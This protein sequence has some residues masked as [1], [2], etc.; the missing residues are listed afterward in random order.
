MRTGLP[1]VLGGAPVV[2]DE[3]PL[4]RPSI[5]LDPELTSALDAVLASGIITKGGRLA[6]LERQVAAFIG[7]EHAVAVSSCTTG[8]MLVLRCLGRTGSVIL[9]SFTF[10]ASGHAALWNGLD[11]VLADIDPDTFTLAPESAARMLD[12]DGAAVMGVHTFGAPCDADALTK[13]ANERGVPLVIDAAP[14]FGARYPDGTM[15][16]TKGIAEVFS[17]SPTK[18]FTTGEGGLIATDDADLARRLRIGRE[19]GNPGNFDSLFVGLNGRM[20]E[21]SAALGLHNLPHLPRWLER[22]EELAERYRAG[23]SDLPGIGFQRI[24]AG[25][26]ST[27]KDFCLTVHA[28]DFGL[29]RDVLA[30]ALG[31]ERVSTRKYFVPPLHRQTV[32]RG[33]AG[34][35]GAV[36]HSEALAG[37]IITVP[38]WSAMTDHQ[39]EEVCAVI[40]RIHEHAGDV[41]HAVARSAALR[42]G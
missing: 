32:Y 16:G 2:A 9:P 24:P 25:A 22:R 6:E 12:E 18:P 36:P 10:M 38:L 15:V 37:R 11:P 14:A 8:L 33:T 40:R 5:A 3:L 35:A 23:L 21:L 27:Y 1:V 29:D 20:P 19:Y 7:V 30:E 13:V 26:R 31:A 34:D 39:V 41:A 4:S 17:F 28:A 42:E